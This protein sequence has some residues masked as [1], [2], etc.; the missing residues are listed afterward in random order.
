[1]EY[2]LDDLIEKFE[3]DSEEYSQTKQAK[4]GEFNLCEAFAEICREIK[5]LKEEL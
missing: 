1:L 4:A 2:E 5:R 3:A